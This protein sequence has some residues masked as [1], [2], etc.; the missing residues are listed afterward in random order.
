[1][2]NK[3]SKEQLIDY[4]EALEGVNAQLTVALRRC[5]ELLVNVPPEI[6][7]NKD[8][9]DMFNKLNQVAE[10][11]ERISKKDKYALS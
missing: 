5:L 8:W 7:G 3:L 4:I 6:S 11:G 1:M 9:K 10:V 2:P